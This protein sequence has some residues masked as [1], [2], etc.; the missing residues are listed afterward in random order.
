MVGKTAFAAKAAPLIQAWLEKETGIP[1]T[2]P[3][4]GKC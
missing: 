4:M 1:Y 2:L 3:K